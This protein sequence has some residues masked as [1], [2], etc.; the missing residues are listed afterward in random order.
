MGV[1][2]GGLLEVLCGFNENGLTRQLK[3]YILVKQ[4]AFPVL[5]RVGFCF[6]R[7]GDSRLLLGFTA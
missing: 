2:K 7:S 6:Q 3:F 5:G 4:L 1:N